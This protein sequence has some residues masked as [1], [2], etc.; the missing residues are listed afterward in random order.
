M[1]KRQIICLAASTAIFVLVW[2]GNRD[3]ALKEDAIRRSGYGEEEI[4][5][6]VLVSGLEEKEIPIQIPVSS[7]KR[8]E[9]EA[10][11]IR[12]ELTGSPS[13]I[14][15]LTQETSKPNSRPQPTRASAPA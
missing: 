11:R 10:R 7:R 14:T 1:Q 9:E 5:Y 15:A 4:W 12:E 6:E 13:Y 8:R 2:I 3:S